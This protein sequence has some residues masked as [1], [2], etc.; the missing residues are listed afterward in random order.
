MTT[1]LLTCSVLTVPCPAESQVWL[2][3]AEV[4]DFAT[5]G[6]TPAAMEHAITWGFGVV[7]SF[8]IFGLVLGWGVGL[9][10]KA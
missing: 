3:P 8:F 10:R 6:I 4:I 1:L 2:A 7:F 5:L 9:I